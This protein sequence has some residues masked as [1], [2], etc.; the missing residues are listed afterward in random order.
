MRMRTSTAPKRFVASPE[1]MTRAA[2]W[3]S[4]ASLACRRPAGEGRAES[5][6][7]PR[8]DPWHGERIQHDDQADD[9]REHDAVAE[10][11]FEDRRFADDL[12][13]RRR[14]GDNRMRDDRL[15]HYAAARVSRAAQ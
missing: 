4:P 1:T 3:P 14:R 11:R 5:S 2:I 15:A 7:L 6:A 10:H 8:S 13:C 9:R 12:L